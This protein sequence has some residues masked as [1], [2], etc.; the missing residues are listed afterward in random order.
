MYKNCLFIILA[1]NFGVLACAGVSH[2][3]GGPLWEDVDPNGL[4]GAWKQ[5]A[6]ER[7]MY[8][9]EMKNIAVN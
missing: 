1:T 8:P 9:M 7:V 6:N 4:A 5:L 3:S 2:A